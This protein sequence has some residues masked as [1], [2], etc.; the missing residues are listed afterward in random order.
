MSQDHDGARV[1]TT[2]DGKQPNVGG[3][4]R[5]LRY[6]GTAQGDV[7]ALLVK[8]ARQRFVAPDR[9]WPATARHATAHHTAQTPMRQT[10]SWIPARHQTP[11]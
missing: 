4:G 6:L 10:A 9:S 3:Y 11:T 8:P 5:L 7:W 2:D 1:E